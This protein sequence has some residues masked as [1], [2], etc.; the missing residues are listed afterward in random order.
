[1]D[2]KDKE[3][4]ALKEEI[5]VLK[6]V[7]VALEKRVAQFERMLG[8]NSS[9][10]SKPPS[11]DGLRK[12]PSPKSLRVKGQKPSGGQKGHKGHTLEQV[13]EVSQ[14]I[15][16]TVETC[17]VCQKSL[18]EIPP[19]TSIKRQVFDIP[20]PNLE[21]TEHC[22]E[23]KI[24]SCGAQTTAAF[25]EN[26]TAPVQ[27]GPRVKALA[28]YFSNQQLIPEDRLQQTF[29]D[30]F[31][32]PISTATLAKINNDFANQVAPIQAQVLEDLKAE[33]VK[34]ADESGLRIGGKTKWL[35]TIGSER[36][37][38]YRV[39]E[40]RGDLLE[41]IQGILVH[42]H[43]KP[44][45]NLKNIEHALCNAHHLRELKALEEIEKEP[46]A[47]KMSRFL[48]I[49]NRLKDPP[50]GRAMQ[51]YDRIVEAGLRFNVSQTQPGGR[52]RRV[53]HNLL[54]RLRD[55]KE[56]T[57]RFLTTPGVPFTNNQSEQDIRMIKVKQKISGGFRTTRGAEVFCLI[58][59][60][61]STRRKQGFNIFHAIL[62]PQFCPQ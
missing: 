50:L 34:G 32:L 56:E 29:E 58:R 61:L 31:S 48:R 49:M 45:F 24:C 21:V 26:I 39:S 16:H 11:S 41:G 2:K 17:K 59:G 7:I 54:L 37:T 9:N 8:M 38:H 13:D 28:V 55:F 57:L 53:G 15:I 12:K 22:A 10:S 40:K 43:W 35:H 23:V 5:V 47:F 46:W 19:S 14:R 30:L 18:V 27:Y 4:E 33:E 52:K 60:F 3:I 44:Y 62:N 36:A 42:D 1:M 25:P 6:A 51:L 20:E